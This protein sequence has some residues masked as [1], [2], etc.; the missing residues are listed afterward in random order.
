MINLSTILEHQVIRDE[1][2]K[3]IP[4]HGEPV[5]NPDFTNL[6]VTPLDSGLEM[7]ST[8]RISALTMAYDKDTQVMYKKA[9]ESCARTIYQHLYG[10]L[11]KDLIVVRNGVMSGDRNEAVRLVCG[12]IDLLEK[13]E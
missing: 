10:E 6:K 12:L 13:G 7:L 3:L 5:I 11:I 8:L 4:K 2:V 9:R 1:D